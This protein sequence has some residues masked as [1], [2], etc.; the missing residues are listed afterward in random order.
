[1]ENAEEFEAGEATMADVVVV[2][3]GV[4][5]LT[6]ARALVGRNA[7]VLLIERGEMLGMESSRAAA[8]MLA[9]QSEADRADEFFALACASREMY[10]LFAESL[11][12]ETGI[13]IELEKTGTLYLAFTETD[14]REI[15]HRYQWQKGAGLC[16]EYLAAEEARALEPCVSQHVRAALLF[17][18]D[19]QVENRKLLTALAASL[20]K[21]KAQIW[22]GANVE[23][24]RVADGRT[25]G[26]E[27]SRGFVRAPA[28]VMACGAWT[29]FIKVKNASDDHSLE[30]GGVSSNDDEASV[31]AVKPV[32]GQILCFQTREKAAR[33]VLYSPRGYLVPRL[34]GRVL[35]GSTTEDAG[36]DK[37]TTDEGTHAIMAHAQEIAP[38]LIDEMQVIDS[39]AGLRPCA[40]DEQPVIGADSEVRG[41]FYATGHYR[42]GI[43]LAP[44]TGELIAKMIVENIASP[45]IEAFTPNRF[46]CAGVR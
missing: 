24:L 9:P 28:V 35:A 44:I 19:V 17:P 2:G 3:G 23:A 33:H 38:A 27:T 34:D 39:W 6:I 7:R 29:S 20:E 18:L 14:E 32:R 31:V 42:N 16:V 37:R 41:L 46:R 30:S 5:G 43:L 10:P 15:R 1:M 13:G 21:S 26:V 11:R 4:I 40:P 45:L 22:T 36:F 12:E 25:L 8:G